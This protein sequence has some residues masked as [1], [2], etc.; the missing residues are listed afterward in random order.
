MKPLHVL[1]NDDEPALRHLV[2]LILEGAGHTVFESNDR[3]QTLA[4]L[5][6]HTEIDLLVT[7]LQ[8]SGGAQIVE[9]VREALSPKFPIIMM[10]GTFTSDTDPGLY[11]VDGIL[12]KPFSGEHL[13][14]A[15]RS[16]MS[17]VT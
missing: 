15:V 1:V 11:K 16:V 2:A 6:G 12:A 13:L 8:G 5:H 4:F 10:S 9:E 3:E 17:Q 14:E 7:D